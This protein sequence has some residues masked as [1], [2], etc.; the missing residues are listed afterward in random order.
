MYALEATFSVQYSWNVVEMF[1]LIISWSSLKMG[2]VWSKTK[3]PGQMLEKTSVRSLDQIF[4]PVLLKVGHNIYL[5]DILN[6]FENR[7]C[8]VKN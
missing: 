6:E 2:H 8:W 4:S 7:S 1:A 3:S 5:D